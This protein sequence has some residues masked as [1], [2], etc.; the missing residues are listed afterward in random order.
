MGFYKRNYEH[1]VGHY[2]T[3]VLVGTLGVGS[4]NKIF[5][6]NSEV[7]EKF[8]HTTI[9]KLLDRSL[10]LLWLLEEMY[11]NILSFLSDATP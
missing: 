4:P 7:L 8:N 1:V 3:N 5:L 6:L 11:D 2:V 9:V 10:Y